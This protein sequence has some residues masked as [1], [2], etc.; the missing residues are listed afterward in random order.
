M[1]AALLQRIDLLR[2]SINLGGDKRIIKELLTLFL[3]TTAESLRKLGVAETN[4]DAVAWLQTV[5]RIKGGA[6]NV[7][8][9]R[10]VALCIEA[11]EI[12]TLP[13]EQSSAVLYH[14]HKEMALLNEAIQKHLGGRDS[15]L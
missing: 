10:L 8:A 3:D 9:K 7:T 5:H 15:I 1:D 4:N 6:Q 2:L 11:E 14:L 12:K 13:H